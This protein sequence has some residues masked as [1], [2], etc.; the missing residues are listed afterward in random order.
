MMAQYKV[1]LDT[2]V[3]NS[4]MIA[5]HEGSVP[6]QELLTRCSGMKIMSS[7]DLRSSYW[8]IPL[9]PA[10]RDY[11]AFLYK[12]KTYRFIVTPF[13]LKTSSAS[14]SRGLD[15][16]LTEEVK[17]FTIIYVDDCLVV[18]RNVSEHLRHLRMLLETL[19][20]A[21]IPVNF[22][23]SQFFRKEINYLRY[24]LSAEGMSTDDT[25]ISATLSHPYPRKPY[26][27]QTD[28]SNYALGRRLKNTVL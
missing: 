1:V 28:S 9:L 25:K 5:D 2:R 13:G 4:R 14:L 6:I 16:V 26:C 10:S 8:Q 7:I 3:L 20:K 17:T 19:K 18:F 23:K 22:E 24:R 12:G 15:R 21:N 11:T 27:I